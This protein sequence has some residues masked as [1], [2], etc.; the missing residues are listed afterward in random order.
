MRSNKILL[1][2]M[3]V[4]FVLITGC[5]TSIKNEGNIIVVE[6]RVDD[7][8][9]YELYNTIEDSQEV[10]KAKAILDNLKWRN[11]HA[12]MAY[13]P[14]Y[15]FH[16]EDRNKGSAGPN[17][18]LWVSPNKDKVELVFEGKYLQLD[19]EKSR[20]LFKIITGKELREV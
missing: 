4:F 14:D 16:F 15:K 13:P 12:S 7:G 17:Y 3:V 1:A 10:Q 6:V 2:I 8:A 11:V 5:A 18:Q 19:E 9:S 20:E